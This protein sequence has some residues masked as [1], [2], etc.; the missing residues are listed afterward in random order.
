M[1]NKMKFT[2]MVKI[3]LAGSYDTPHLI[4]QIGNKKTAAHTENYSTRSNALRARRTWW[5]IFSR[6]VGYD[7]VVLDE[8]K[9]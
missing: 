9:K 2:P 4:I 8:T 1:G 3:I 6:Q 5:K 7:I